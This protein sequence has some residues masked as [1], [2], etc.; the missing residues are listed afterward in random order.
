MGPITSTL[1]I[2]VDVS[3]IFWAKFQNFPISTC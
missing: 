2:D 1:K 3:L